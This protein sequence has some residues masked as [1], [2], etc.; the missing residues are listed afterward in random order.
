MH[1]SGPQVANLSLRYQ[2]KYHDVET[3]SYYYGIRHYDPAT[4][5]WL[6]RDPLEEQGG[7]NLYA[8]VNNGPINNVD[9]LGMTSYWKFWQRDFFVWQGIPMAS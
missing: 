3:N 5:R 2:T 9:Y 7:Y 8:F 1:R 6:S 4:C